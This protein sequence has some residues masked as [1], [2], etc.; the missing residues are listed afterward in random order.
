MQITKQRK[1]IICILVSL[2][3]LIGVLLLIPK[4]KSAN[5]ET[6]ASNDTLN[7]TLTTNEDGESS[8]KVA[9][10]PAYRSQ[11]EFVVVPE[12]Y[13][14]LPVTEVAANG[15]VSCTKLSK[16]ILPATVK[17]LGNNAFMNCSKLQYVTM[18]NVESIGT[19]AFGMCVT[20]ERLFIPNSVTEVGSNILR[21]NANTI[22]VQ[23][24]VEVVNQLW[25][26]TWSNYFTGEIVFDAEIDEYITYREVLSTDNQTVIGYEIKEEQYLGDIDADV[27]IYNSV[28]FDEELGYLP[29]LNICPEA[30]LFSQVNSI[31]IRDRHVD[32]PDAPSFTHKINI[33]SNAFLFA[34]VQEIK[35]EVGVTFNQPENLQMAYTESLFDGQ[36]IAGD[37]DGF[38]TR[39]F[40]ESVIK[41]IT[42]PSNMDLITERMFYNCTYLESIKIDGAKYNG[43]NILPNVNRIGA[44][45]FSSCVALQNITIPKCVSY[46]DEAAFTNLGEN[47]DEQIIYVDIYEDD[48]PQGWDSNWAVNNKDNVKINYKEFTYITVVLYD[49]KEIS[50]GVKPGQLVPVINEAIEREGYTVNGIYSSEEDG[51]F[52][53]YNRNLQGARVWNVG[54]P[55]TLYVNWK[56]AEYS[57]SY[58]NLLDGKNHPL[59]PVKYTI[60][61][62]DIIFVEPTGRTGY[63]GTWDLASIEK[64]STG[65]KVIKAVWQAIEY[66][67]A[68]EDLLG[69]T[70]P[71]TNPSSYTIESE[72]I[73]FENPTD[74]EG[75]TGTWD[76]AGIEQGSIGDRV[77]TA[78]W[79][80]IEYTITYDV[81]LKGQTNPNPTTYTIEDEITFANF[82]VLGYSFVWTPAKINKGTTGNI[83]IT[84]IWTNL[85]YFIK[86]DVDLKGLTNPNTSFY[87]VDDEITFIK[88]EK[89]GYTFEWIPAGIK[90][91]TTGDLTVEG[92]WTLIDYSI[93]YNVWEGTIHSNP[94]KYNVENPVFFSEA[95]YPNYDVKWDI[96]N[97]LNFAKD[98]TVTAEYTYR[99]DLKDCYNTLRGR[100]ELT[101]I[102]QLNYLRTVIT[103]GKTFYVTVNYGGNEWTAIPNFEG[104]LIG[105]VSNIKIIPDSNSTYCGFIN[106]NSGT[107]MD[108]TLDGTLEVNNIHVNE[109][110]RYIGLLCGYNVGEI[111]RCQVTSSYP[112]TCQMPNGESR[113]IGML[114]LVDHRAR[115]G[116]LVGS[117]SRRA[118]LEGC[119]NHSN[120]YSISDI[121]GIAAETSGDIIK[122]HNLGMIRYYGSG[123]AA[124]IG[125]IVGFASEALISQCV[126]HNGIYFMNVEPIDDRNFQPSIGTIAGAIDAESGARVE[127]CDNINADI[128]TGSLKGV[129]LDGVGG[130]VGYIFD[131]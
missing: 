106:I 15:F 98:L 91:E 14:G 92:V 24:S 12:T 22:Y 36:P 59:N 100:Y 101:T 102:A 9:V 125:G 121:G 81:D 118:T 67:I 65:N 32:D 114:N 5:A 69:G 23:S 41:S 87:D 40:E 63:T 124:Q 7:F 51:G 64:G 99:D 62:D 37:A 3:L 13:D 56:L 130:Q 77:I 96:P 116:G 112:L 131:E 11:V 107:I 78:V 60:E 38:S 2:V 54:D 35:F 128:H 18:P 20:L 120:I 73:V 33:R 21:N 85:E 16:V 34:I 110:S 26:S 25:S 17:N 97:T 8:Y 75:Y 115:L 89:P 94:T 53:Y 104:T 72:S 57:I 50:I 30:F 80:P 103:A 79:Q 71:S 31:T 105:Y 126:N 90:K 46:V 48:L 119:Y 39:V 27:V 82:D 19:N 123:A 84:G 86:Y 4:V 68:Y 88:L 28:C 76:I 45:A 95:T 129:Q 47:I 113:I 49:D 29:V 1:F 6:I 83:T 70:N 43:T 58:E 52:Q 127:D 74:R 61:T 122:C 55:E 93:T 111:I 109:R 10:K 117:N 108:F 44:E 66:S 42:L